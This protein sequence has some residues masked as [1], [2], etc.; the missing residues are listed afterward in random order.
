MRLP[1]VFVISFVTL[2]VCYGYPHTENK[3]V[4]VHQPISDQSFEDA[5]AF[6]SEHQTEATY[7]HELQEDLQF[8]PSFPQFQNPPLGHSRP[9]FF[10]QEA[11]YSQRPVSPFQQLTF[12]TYRGGSAG[13][14]K[15]TESEDSNKYGLLGSGN[16]GVI[17]GGT[18]YNDNEGEPAGYE[19]KFEQY[20]QNGHGRPSLIL[21]RIG[22]TSR[23]QQQEQFANFRDFADIN[24]PSYSQYVIVY[25]NKN[26]SSHDDNQSLEKGRKPKNIIEQLALL[27]QETVSATP[28][29]EQK[30]SKTKQK[31]SVVSLEKKVKANLSK[32]ETTTPFDLDNLSSFDKENQQHYILNRN[33]NNTVDHYTSITTSY[34]RTCA[35]STSQKQS[36]HNFHGT[37]LLLSSST[38]VALMEIAD[39]IDFP[40]LLNISDI[41]INNCDVNHSILDSALIKQID[42][43]KSI[44]FVIDES[45]DNLNESD[46]TIHIRESSVDD[47]IKDPN[48]TP[49]QSEV[50]Q[51]LLDDRSMGNLT[52]TLSTYKEHNKE[53]IKDN[54]ISTEK[55]FVEHTLTNNRVQN[56]SSNQEDTDVERATRHLSVWHQSECEDQQILS[57]KVKREALANLRN[58][59]N[60]IRNRTHK[61]LRPVKRLKLKETN[62]NSSKDFLPCEDHL[63][64]HN[65]KSK[66]YKLVD[67]KDPQQT[68]FQECLTETEKILLNTYSRFVIRGKLGRGV[69][70]LFSPDMKKR[71]EILL[72]VCHNFVKGYEYVFHASEKG[73]VDAKVS[74]LLLLMMDERAGQFQGK[75]LDE[76]DIKLDPV[77]EEVDVLEKAIDAIHEN[78][79]DTIA[80]V[81]TNDTEENQ[82]K[83]ILEKNNKKHKNYDM[84][85]RA[86]IP[87]CKAFCKKFGNKAGSKKIGS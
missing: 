24:T 55:Y 62:T 69:P 12:D 72:K 10:Q 87:H 6:P 3:N 37:I 20:Y 74:K 33:Y 47:S 70:V 11:A 61:K 5:A 78:E 2:A 54:R 41:D 49:I 77:Y 19:S 58:K 52:T 48:Y 9:F 34:Q 23:T 42:S 51:E 75:S 28:S 39:N 15:Y 86:K 45:K 46:P 35:V 18:F 80:V 30:L 63:K 29:A 65:S 71:F 4:I 53:I 73:F 16:F 8:Y 85:R 40:N 44:D 27:D 68:E 38:D 31:L 1:L 59:G 21:G 32:K 60:F 22:K 67:G 79:N 82:E 43:I 17:S 81:D 25:T 7:S 36:R 76:I 56:M 26:N 84:D 57:L 13:G 14:D 50:E 66:S 83:E 64:S